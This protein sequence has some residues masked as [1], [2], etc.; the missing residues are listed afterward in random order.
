MGG[1]KPRNHAVEALA[2]VFGMNT[3]FAFLAIP[4]SLSVAQSPMSQTR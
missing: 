3:M 4:A 1:V 2:I